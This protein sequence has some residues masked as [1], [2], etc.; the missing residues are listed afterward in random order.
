MRFLITSYRDD[1]GHFQQPGCADVPDFMWHLN[2][3]REHDNLPP[4]NLEETKAAITS[5]VE[6]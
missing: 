5:V 6:G 4:L 1:M 2:K 3:A